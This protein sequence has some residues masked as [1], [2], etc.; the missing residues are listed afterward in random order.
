MKFYEI[1]FT[2]SGGLLGCQFSETNWVQQFFFFFLS[3]FPGIT[4][5]IETHANRAKIKIMR[6]NLMHKILFTYY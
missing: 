3:D 1:C 6:K 5:N 4:E 2:S